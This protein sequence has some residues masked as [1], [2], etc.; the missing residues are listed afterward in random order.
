M[1]D[2]R[3]AE[4]R[5][6]RVRRI[7]PSKLYPSEAAARDLLAEVDRLRDELDAAHRALACRECDVTGRCDRDPSMWD[8][9]C[10][11]GKAEVLARI[12]EAKP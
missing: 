8:K 2:E 3:L 7:D 11:C 12:L 10:P 4:I 6:L 5:A 1:T 9:L